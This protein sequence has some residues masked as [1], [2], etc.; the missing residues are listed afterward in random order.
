MPCD[1]PRI[2]I[3]YVSA[4]AGHRRA[5]EALEVVLQ[6]GGAQVDVL[7]AAL[8][9]Q[10]VFRQVYVAGGLG[11][12]T[13]LP[14][15]YGW[16]YRLTDRPTVDY[17][18]R[19]P[20]NT[21]QLIG[22]RRLK[23]VIL[24]HAPDAVIST[25]FLA[26]ELA[27]A[28]RRGHSLAARAYTVITDF[29]PHR[30]WEHAGIDGYFV[31][32]EATAQRLVADGIRRESIYVTG[33]PISPEFCR[34]LERRVLKVRL[35]FDPD[36]P[37]ILVTGGGLGAGA[38]EAIAREVI[39]QHAGAQFAFITGDNADLRAR[40]DRRAGE[41]GWR[42]VGFVANMHEWLSAAD[43]AIGKA[44]AMTGS[45]MLATGLPFIVPPGM[46]GH[47]AR[48]A[49]NLQ[50]CGAAVVTTSIR[51]AVT[52]ARMIAGQADARERMRSAARSAARP[53]AAQDIAEIVLRELE[54]RA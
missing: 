46:R 40:L 16:L 36:D 33:I 26:A 13:R 37:L 1:K 20:R 48:N 25:H 29:A 31:A 39:E 51:E 15:L 24:G 49:A 18:V 44:G 21:A 50:A 9:V 19:G 43:V 17:L 35:G 41:A 23:R 2:L 28:W 32:G 10:P 38:I 7:D 53:R 22:A 27:A 52:T 5:A 11:L 3:L 30:M 14:R 6:A 8:F 34:P 54:D 4:G 42:V 45:E 47:E 12:I